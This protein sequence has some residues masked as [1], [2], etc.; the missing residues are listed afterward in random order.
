[1]M[2]SGLLRSAALAVLL[3]GGLAMQGCT[4]TGGAAYTPG[5]MGEVERAKYEQDREA[6]LAQQ[7]DYR[8]R[9]DFIETVGFTADYKAVPYTHLKLRTKRNV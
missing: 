6:I 7:G 4:S 9:F 8:V 1:M 2:S 5:V 3:A